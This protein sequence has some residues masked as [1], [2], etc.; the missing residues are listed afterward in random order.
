M[1]QGIRSMAMLSITALLTVLFVSSA[2]AQ[3]PVVGST[4]QAPPRVGQMVAQ[5]PVPPMMLMVPSPSCPL[6]VAQPSCPQSLASTVLG[7]RRQSLYGFTDRVGFNIR[8]KGPNVDLLRV[9]I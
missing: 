1:S 5:Y 6:I 4:I 7:Q 8:L 3:E 2:Y 9:P